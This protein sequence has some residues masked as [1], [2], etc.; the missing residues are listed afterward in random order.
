[1]IFHLLVN[2]PVGIERTLVSAVFE[3]LQRKEQS[4]TAN[5]SNV[6]MLRKALAK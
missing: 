5:I 4:P 3:E 1:M 6:R 2:V